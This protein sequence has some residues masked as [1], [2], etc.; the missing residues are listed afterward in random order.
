MSAGKSIGNVTFT[1]N[2]ATITTDTLN[3][4]DAARFY[5]VNGAIVINAAVQPTGTT[6]TNAN[7]TVTTTPPVIPVGLT[8]APANSVG[9]INIGNGILSGGSGAGAQ[10]GIF[11]TGRI[12]SIIGA[13]DAVVRGTIDSSNSIG[14]I[15]LVNGSLINARIMVSG[16]FAQTGN[17]P[18]P[19]GLQLPDSSVFANNPFFE[20]GSISLPG[21]GGILSAFIAADNI[22]PVSAPGFGIM[23][24]LFETFQGTISSITAGGYGFRDNAVEADNVGT[25]SATGPGPIAQFSNF[26][27]NAQPSGGFATYGGNSDPFEFTAI[28]DLRLF[29]NGDTRG[30]VIQPPSRL[31][32]DHRAL[33][34][35]TSLRAQAASIPFRVPAGQQR[36]SVRQ[37]HR[38]DQHP[39]RRHR[40]GRSRRHQPER[41]RPQQHDLVGQTGQPHRQRQCAGPESGSRRS[42]RLRQHRRER[43][44]PGRVQ[45]LHR[46]P[47]GHGQQLHGEGPVG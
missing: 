29:I 35:S 43:L 47:G 1:G 31:G 32:P 41:R 42:N 24:S 36:D 23:E 9:T 20:I 21:N 18:P 10:A 26:T 15:N 11:A 25:I 39:G 46:C 2:V 17:F 40:P 22:G 6:V 7:G 37:R 12:N 16:G 34:T 45:S 13:N 14:T 33:L 3:N 19:P 4:T 5:G 44:Q 30:I 28:T 27:K 8:T 38:L